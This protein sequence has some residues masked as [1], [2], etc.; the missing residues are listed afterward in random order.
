MR[1][2]EVRIDGDAPLDEVKKVI[3]AAADEYG[4]VTVFHDFWR[5]D[6]D[7][8]DTED[9]ILEVLERSQNR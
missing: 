3:K 7:S 2:M 5:F 6:F 4:R 8:L 9:E 1:N